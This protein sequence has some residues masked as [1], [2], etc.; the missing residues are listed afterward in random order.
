ML[1]SYQSLRNGKAMDQPALAR[2]GTRHSKS[3]AQVLGRWCVQRGFVYM[4]KSVRRERM[5]E[6]REVSD[7]KLSGGEMEDL[8][9]L[10]PPEA[11]STFK[12]LYWKCVNRDTTK[13]SIMEGVRMDITID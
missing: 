11:L 7:F 8:D 12:G 10:T 9:G 4:P 3:P 6:N 13:D 2:I 5:V 1:Q